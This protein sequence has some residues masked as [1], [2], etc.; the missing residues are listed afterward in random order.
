MRGSRGLV[1]MRARPRNVA[2]LARRM[3]TRLSAIVSP[4]TSSVSVCRLRQCAPKTGG[5]GASR[6]SIERSSRTASAK[7]ACWWSRPTRPVRANASSVGQSQNAN[8]SRYK[9]DG[10]SRLAGFCSTLALL[11]TLINRNR[12]FVVAGR[13]CLCECQAAESG[14]GGRKAHDFLQR[15]CPK[16]RVRYRV[17]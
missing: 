4:Q 17:S 9:T 2:R 7:K 1:G 14:H 5:T 16:T 6:R 12:L 10:K 15:V 13:L 3:A 8:T 11:S